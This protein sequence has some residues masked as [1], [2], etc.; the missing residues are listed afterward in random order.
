ML[1]IEKLKGTETST[2]V[3][4][5]INEI[6]ETGGS[7]AALTG[8]ADTDL[9]NLTSTGKS[10]ASGLSM[11]SNRY[12]DLTL[13]ASGTEYTAPA[14]GWVVV[15]K[16]GAAESKY[17]EIVNVTSDIITSDEATTKQTGL[18]LYIPVKK[19]DVFK[20][21]YN[22]TGATNAFRFIYAEGAE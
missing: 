7:S 13:G 15:R 5:K 16:V 4:L 14:N 9:T 18:Q 11:P 17:I 3:G 8:K 19:D 20:V 2:E 6:I 10:L 21:N 22:A 1:D 12:I